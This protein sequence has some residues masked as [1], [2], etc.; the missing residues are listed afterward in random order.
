MVVT[1]LQ[2][3]LVVMTLTVLRITGQI[4][5]RMSL[6]WDLSDAFLRMRLPLWFLGGRRQ[7]STAILITLYQ[8]YNS[9]NDLSLLMLTLIT[10]LEVVFVR[11]LYCKVTLFFSL[12]ILYSLKGVTMYSLHIMHRELYSVSLRIEYLCKLFGILLHGPL[13][14]LPCL[15]IY[16]ITYLYQYGLIYT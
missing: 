3:L 15:L 16:S 7:N 2:T 1:I 11:F 5:C 10:W 4:F 8:R 6:C 12:S 13:S 9:Q 14:L